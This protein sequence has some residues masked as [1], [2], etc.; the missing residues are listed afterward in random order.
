MRDID[1]LLGRGTALQTY[2]L[3]ANAHKDDFNTLKVDEL[4][5]LLEDEIEELAAEVYKWKNGKADLIELVLE[6]ADVANFS[7]MIILKAEE[8]NE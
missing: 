8:D 6:A 7:H 2:K 5:A 1:K 4:F 3:L